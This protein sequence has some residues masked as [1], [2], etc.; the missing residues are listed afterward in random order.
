MMRHVLFS[1]TLASATL[2]GAQPAAA[3]TATPD[4]PTISRQL[5]GRLAP[6]VKEFRFDYAVIKV[7]AKD[8]D[9][10]RLPLDT[11]KLAKKA[12]EGGLKGTTDLL[13]EE[14]TPWVLF[15]GGGTA[16][17]GAS[18]YRVSSLASP[19]T[20]SRGDARVSSRS[21]S[22]EISDSMTLSLQVTPSIAGATGSATGPAVAQLAYSISL[23]HFDKLGS[24]VQKVGDA[25]NIEWNGGSICESDKDVVI[26]RT[27]RVAAGKSVDYYFILIPRNAD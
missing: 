23:N 22:G 4:A 5:A 11:K 12:A 24:D 26:E 17:I 8:K 15:S 10:R 2:V 7:V 25:V 3:P 18:G 1:L 27:S 19:N 21:E 16:V 14:G 20:F 6:T 9:P 13:A